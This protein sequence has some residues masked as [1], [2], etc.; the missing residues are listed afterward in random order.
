LLDDLVGETI[1]ITLRVFGEEDPA[2]HALR[3]FF[4]LRVAA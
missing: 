1:E 2:G 4:L 3:T